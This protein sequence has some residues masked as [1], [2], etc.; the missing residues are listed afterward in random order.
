MNSIPASKIV[1]VIPGVLGA[2][3]NPLSLNGVFLTESTSVPI[4]QVLPFST[5][6]DVEDFFGESS[7]EA[8]LAAIYFGGYQNGTTLP[9]TLYFAQYN[10]AAVA[11]YV[12]SAPLNLTLNQLKALSGTLVLSVDGVTVTS[13]AINLSGATSFSNAATLISSGLTGGTSFSGTG[14]ITTDV[15]NVTVL[16]SGALHVG[17]VIVGVGVT[18]G[19][20]ILSFGSGTGGIGT[21]NVST[22]ADVTSEAL[23]VAGK[24]SCV[25]NATLDEF[26]VLSPT[27]GVNSEVG[28]ASDGALSTGLKLTLATGAILSPGAAAGTPG[29]VMDGVALVTQNWA[30]FM[31]VFEPVLDDKLAFAD[32]VNA[33]GQ[34]YA[35][36][37]FDSDPTALQ[38]NA[39]GSFGALTKTD[40]GVI[41]VWNPDGSIAAFICGVAGSIN[42]T[43]PNGRITFD[44]K[45]QAGLVAD[46]TDAT[47]ADNL[48]GNGYNF[49]A[50][51][52]TANQ[53][54][55]FLQPGQISG[56]WKWIDPYINQIYL[57]SQLQL[58][59]MALLTAAP[60]IPYNASGYGLIRQAAMDPIN[61][62]IL[63]G[64]IRAGV[65]LSAAQAQEMNA[66]AGI[67]ISNTVQNVG[68][69]LQILDASP[70]VRAARGSPPM[71]L[72]YTDGGSIQKINLASIDVE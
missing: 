71:T 38:A 41:A 24:G 9:G 50:S 13:A 7:V 43:A 65:T 48:T 60:S 5:L 36:V 2:G 45:G 53:Q 29:S 20:H 31:T 57:N 11:G 56:D 39:T 19:C 62:A 46:V 16:T 67:S 49:Y 17:D 4:G 30:T 68:W 55:T 44:F 18:S 66:A 15:L 58:A 70:Q 12:R 35:Y 63:N 40:N 6:Q 25:Y 52:A 1:S 64:T 3:G 32:W 61:Q 27:T 37:C 59:F 8:T 42:F 23:T 72:W 21:Y 22:T 34:R 69:Y 33:S 54:F 10:A 51:Y 14:T 26:E 47:I 28:Y